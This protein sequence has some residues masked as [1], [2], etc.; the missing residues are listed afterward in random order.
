MKR[1]LVTILFISI[2]VI[3]GLRSQQIRAQVFTERANK[4]VGNQTAAKIEN[5]N[6]FDKIR[7]RS[8][9]V[10][11][12]SSAPESRKSK[13][14][15]PK[16][17]IISHG[18]GMKNT[19]YSFIADTL[20]AHGYFVA[21]IQHEL[22]T[23]APMPTTGKP[24]EVRRP[25]WERGVQ[26]IIF[27]IEELKRTRPELDF[28]NLLLVGHSNGGDMT[29]LFAEH[30]PKRARKIISLDNRR[31][32]L[33]RVRHPQILTIRSSDQQADA[34]VLPTLA[35]QKKFD[36]KIVKLESTIHNDM[37]DGGS[38]EQKREISQIISGFLSEGR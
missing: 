1:E 18:Y 26:N 28:K 15:K 8:V 35:E 5:L 4:R 16:L 3:G 11:L 30:Y 34:G 17:A 21:S 31:M 12:Y 20:V 2:L 22:P 24:A 14:P 37:W 9:P 32:P 27:V 10:V 33:P 13:A 6:L 29:M 19:E 38:D 7:N 36:I 25:N 23:D